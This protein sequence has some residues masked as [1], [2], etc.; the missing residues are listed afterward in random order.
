MGG[1]VGSP[2]FKALF[3]LKIYREALQ[4][5]RKGGTMEPFFGSM[6]GNLRF[7]PYIA[8]PVKE[9][10]SSLSPITQLNTIGTP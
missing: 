7:P 3:I 9:L 4:V 10:P 1:T 6:G 5:F 8:I 2:V